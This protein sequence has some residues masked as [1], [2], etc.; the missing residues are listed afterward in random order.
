MPEQVMRAM[1]EAN[2]VFVDM[3]ELQA[4][5][6]K[7]IATIMKTESAM[8]SAGSFSAMLLGCAA[9]LT[10]KDQSRIEALRNG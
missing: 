3:L 8:I 10:G 5:C 2:D 1:Q 4:A 9:C 6:G 7:R